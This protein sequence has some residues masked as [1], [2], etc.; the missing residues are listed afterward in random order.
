VA[1][2]F[3]NDYWARESSE[4]IAFLGSDLGGLSSVEAK[5]RRLQNGSNSLDEGDR[6]RIPRLL[7]RQFE[8]PLV[9]VL[10][11]GALLL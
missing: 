5:K 7:I 4:L 11:F 6:V 8:S 9:L 2:E 10:I 3:L 1:E